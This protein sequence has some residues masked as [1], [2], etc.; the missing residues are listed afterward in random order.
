MLDEPSPRLEDSLY[1]ESPRLP[2][3]T[4]Q[5]DFSSTFAGLNALEIASVSD[6][7]K[8]LRQK[9]IQHII[10]GIWKGDIV[11]WETLS[12]H[13]CKEAKEY[14]PKIAD[15]YCR[16]RVP[17]Y[18]KVFEV[19]F[20]AGFLTFY[21]VV[22]VQKHTPYV[23]AA[24]VMLYVWLASFTYN[25]MPPLTFFEYFTNASCRVRGVLRCRLDILRDRLLVLVGPGDNL[26]RFGLLRSQGD[27]LT[28]T[29]T[30]DRCCI[31]HSVD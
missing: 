12:T 30:C 21:Y 9:T 5:S 16:L 22:L 10:D 3:D 2:T 27:R 14:R 17:L 20:F 13:S 28:R 25:G 15:P 19:L 29:C 8:F 6:A 18:L 1:D 26:C 24:E 7:K 31:R 23:T 11:F 4:F